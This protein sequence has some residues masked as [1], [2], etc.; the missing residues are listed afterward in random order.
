MELELSYHSKVLQA[1]LNPTKS[2]YVIL[3][4]CSVFLTAR[5]ALKAIFVIL[6]LHFSGNLDGYGQSDSFSADSD[7][8]HFFRLSSYCDV[9]YES[10]KNAKAIED[11]ADKALEE[12]KKQYELR[13]ASLKD[14][15]I[16][17]R[18]YEAVNNCDLVKTNTR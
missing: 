11:N 15:E 10:L 13:Q 4:L 2:L 12:V 14:I 1:K 6:R 18:E 17:L 7:N 8:T 9:F 5:L 3:L 16:L